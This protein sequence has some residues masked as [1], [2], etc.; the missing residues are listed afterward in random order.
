MEENCRLSFDRVLLQN[1]MEV[2]LPLQ[3]GNGVVSSD[4]QKAEWHCF[5]W[6][7]SPFRRGYCNNKAIIIQH[8]RKLLNYP[9][10][11]FLFQ[12]LMLQ[13][14]VLLP[15][16]DFCLA[17]FLS[18]Y[19]QQTTHFSY[20]LALFIIQAP[21]QPFSWPSD[22]HGS[23]LKSNVIA[24]KKATKKKMFFL[25][26]ST[27]D[28]GRLHILLFLCSVCKFLANPKLWKGS[29]APSRHQSIGTEN[30]NC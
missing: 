19:P 25:S 15:S 8:K 27:G 4:S 2:I 3:R 20:Y 10:S 1:Y 26:Q 9:Q 18:V 12:W 29:L 13:S 16:K 7:S 22:C 14:A 6:H 17:I 30:S 24:R 28:S 21:L 23:R 11:V 5:L